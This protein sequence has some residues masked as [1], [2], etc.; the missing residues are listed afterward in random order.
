[1]TGVLGN[2]IKV[3]QVGGCHSMRCP[4]SYWSKEVVEGTMGDHCTRRSHDQI[5][6]SLEQIEDQHVDRRASLE[7]GH[8]PINTPT[9]VR[10][11]VEHS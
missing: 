11:C 4:H 5:F 3:S 1:M 7:E 8:S 10:A 9:P 2:T 6:P